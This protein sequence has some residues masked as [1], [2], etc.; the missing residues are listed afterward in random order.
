MAPKWEALQRLTDEELIEK[1]DGISKSTEAGLAFYRDEITRRAFERASAAAH[2]LAAAA[3]DEARASRRLARWTM[4]VA[5]IATVAAILALV[6][7]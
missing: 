5:V 7:G 4:V 1:Y 2:E 6:L 3:L